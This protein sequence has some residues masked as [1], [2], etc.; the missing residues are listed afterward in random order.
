MFNERRGMNLYWVCDNN[1]YGAYVFAETRNRA[2]SMMVGHFYDEEYIYLKAYLKKRDVGGEE[3]IV[4]D[5]T[6]KDYKRVTDL[7]FRFMT[8]EELDEWV[9]RW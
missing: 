9:D 3:A 7:D 1:E 6:D 5:D 2:R 4:D 8:E